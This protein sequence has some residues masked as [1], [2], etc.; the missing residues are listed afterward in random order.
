[1]A[2]EGLYGG[3]ASALASLGIVGDRLRQLRNIDAEAAE[4]A[5]LYE[6]AVAQLRELA[7]WLRAYG[8][9]LDHDPNRLAQIEERLEQIQ[10]LKKKYGGTIEALLSTVQDVVRQLDE[11][12]T[13]DMRA[14][15][16]RASTAKELSRLQELA[17]QLSNHR[18]EAASQLER[19]VKTELAALRMEQTQFQIVVREERDTLGPTG[20]D[21]VEYLLSANP[22]EPLMPLGRVASG[23]ELSRIMLA[24]KTVLAET[25]GV[26]VLI[27]DEV[28]AGIGGSVAAGERGVRGRGRDALPRGSAR[29]LRDRRGTP[30]RTDRPAGAL[31]STRRPAAAAIPRRSSAPARS[32]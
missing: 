22:G 28:D 23:G 26:P 5:E 4:G 1:E 9:S 24:I 16:L 15:E 30:A 10:R 7:Q 13:S 25:D 20:C 6:G 11:L 19:R 18:R 21:R 12:E 32:A 17:R 31:S 29:R 2:Y 27:F 14:A 8:E 3:E